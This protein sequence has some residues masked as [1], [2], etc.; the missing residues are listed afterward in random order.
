[1]ALSLSPGS[2]TVVEDALEVFARDVVESALAWGRLLHHD[3]EVRVE[4]D[5]A[6]LVF[7]LVPPEP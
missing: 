1:M 2:F 3:G 4:W 6:D 7:V 5:G